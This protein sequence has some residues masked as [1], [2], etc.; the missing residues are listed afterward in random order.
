MKPVFFATD[1]TGNWLKLK[2]A[3]GSSLGN[4][5]RFYGEV[6]ELVAVFPIK[7]ELAKSSFSLDLR[8]LPKAEAGDD[9]LGSNQSSCT[10]HLCL[11]RG[12]R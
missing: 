8:G 2:S 10:L 9:W 4:P 3:N 11:R 1:Q 7:N 5:L 6:A 12:G